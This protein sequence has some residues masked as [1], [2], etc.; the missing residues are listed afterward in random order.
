MGALQGAGPL[1]VPEARL[2]APNRFPSP[3]E[4]Q[5]FDR[6]LIMRLVRVAAAV[7]FLALA[8]AMFGQTQ[9]LRAVGSCSSDPSLGCATGG[10]A[11]AH[12][13]CDGGNDCTTCEPDSGSSCYHEDGPHLQN[14]TEGG[15]G[16]PM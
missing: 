13:K 15:G 16:G 2:W 14:Y 8:P 9:P 7:M 6:D 5:M 1:G 4:L 11:T 3:K 12:R 10:G